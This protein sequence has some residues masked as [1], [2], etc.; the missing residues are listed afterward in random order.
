MNSRTHEDL[1]L[2]DVYRLQNPRCEIYDIVLHHLPRW[3]QKD[4]RPWNCQ[5]HHIIHHC[6]RIDVL[7]NLIMVSSDIHV[8]WV[9]ANPVD[10]RIVCLHAKLRKRE[11]NVGELDRCFGKNRGSGQ[12]V[13]AWIEEAKCSSWVYPLAEE[14]IGALT[15]EKRK[16]GDVV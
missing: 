9:H 2:R 11:F 12:P 16:G 10:A 14:L 1:V 13:L 6:G 3:L 5:L 7:S 15:G 8:P 4:S